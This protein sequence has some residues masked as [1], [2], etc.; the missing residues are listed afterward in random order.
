MR[1]LVRLVEVM[2]TLRSDGGCP[3]DAEQ[4]HES[5]APYAIEEAYELVEAIED[6]DREELRS[7][8]GDLLLQVV[9]HARV[10]QEHPDRPFDLDDVAKACSDKLVER[11]PHVFAD[12][13][14]ADSDQVTANWHAIKARTMGRESVMDG[15][16]VALPALQRAQKVLA[17]AD[18]AGLDVPVPT[19]DDIG[20]RLLALA[21]EASAQGIDAESALRDAVRALE[22]HARETERAGARRMDG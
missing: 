21:A 16:P 15:V 3:W 9:F 20:S 14:A 17:R 22:S 6:G 11:H 18:R 13:I 4:T 19:G 8:L 7:E 12:V 1:E 5:L 2:D 10:A